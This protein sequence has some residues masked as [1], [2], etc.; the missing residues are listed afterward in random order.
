MSSETSTDRPRKGSGGSAEA[1]RA[2]A[3]GD[4]FH[5]SHF[6][7]LLSLL[8]ATVAVLMAR[9]SAPAQLILVSLTIGAAGLAGIAVHRMLAP[10]VSPASDVERQPLSE[11]MRLDLEREKALTLRSIKELEFDRAMGKVS[12]QDFDDMAARLR[13]RAL[14]IM[15]QLDEGS[16]AYR[17]L[18][19]KELARRV[20]AKPP[21]PVDR[22]P[23][24]LPPDGGAH[25]A[26]VCACGT[27]NDAD[28]RFC[29]SCGSRLSAA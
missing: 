4:G 24:A 27:R 19:E 11:R 28:A 29:K 2:K 13:A 3:E 16:H 15:R 5:V 10:L 7:V 9:P 26:A 20:G 18:I 22:P 17:A 25:A 12:P 8:A 6:F 1:L 14:G 23:V 21:T